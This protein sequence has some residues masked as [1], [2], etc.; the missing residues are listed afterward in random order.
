MPEGM[1]LREFIHRQFAGLEIVSVSQPEPTLL[2]RNVVAVTDD[3][4]Q[5]RQAVLTL[6]DLEIDDARLGFAVLDS[7]FSSS[8]THS[9]EG[10][11]RTDSVGATR[12]V[13]TRAVVG[14]MF[15]AIIGALVIGLAATILGGGGTGL[16][17]AI[18][19]AFAG[20]VLG[21]ITT[22]FAGMGGSD[23]YRQTFL[24]P[25]SS[26]ICLVSLHTN[27]RKEADLARDRLSANAWDGLLD[28]DA[29]GRARRV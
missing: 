22:V 6:E 3:V 15:G 29:R 21:A 14:A 1:T 16:A 28:V 18:V 11:G 26:Q 17:G 5:A 20:A 10:D 24:P 2:D 27:D 13:A 8:W 25:S 9:E 7:P 12:M 4:D 23:A 19:G